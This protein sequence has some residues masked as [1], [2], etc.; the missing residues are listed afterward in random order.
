MLIVVHQRNVQFFFQSLLYV[1]RLR[2]FDI[3]QI[4]STKS[5]C[6]SFHRFYEFI[7]IFFIDLNIENIDARKYFEKQS[8]SLHHWLGSFWTDI[9]QSENGRSVRDYGYQISFGSVLINRLR[10]I[11]NGHTRHSNT[12]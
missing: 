9:A 1:K 2:C 6:N 11:V 8:F 5:W 10:I 3:F 7:R 12:W 4:D